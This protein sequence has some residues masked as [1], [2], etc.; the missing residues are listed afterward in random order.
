MLYNKDV[1]QVC[2]HC[3]FGQSFSAS[4]ELCRRYGPVSPTFTC[5]HFKYD[6]LR[7]T[8][9]RPARILMPPQEDAFK[10]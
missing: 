10:L 9:P 3:L 2:A 5:P 8:P 6:P 1:P 4:H 7:R